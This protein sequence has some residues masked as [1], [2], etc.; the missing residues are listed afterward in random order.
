[1]SNLNRQS[2]ECKV[3]FKKRPFLFRSEIGIFDIFFERMYEEKN[4]GDLEVNSN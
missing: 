4:F 3:K 2:F 1:M